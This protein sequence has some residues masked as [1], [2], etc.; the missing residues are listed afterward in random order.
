VEVL[1]CRLPTYEAAW[2]QL[3]NVVRTSADLLV[4]RLGVDPNKKG[5]P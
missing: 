3:F 1:A 4:T 5:E 2:Q